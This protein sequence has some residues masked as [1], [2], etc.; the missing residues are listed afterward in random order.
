MASPSTID[1][2]KDAA[3]DELAT[4]TRVSVCS[5]EPANFAG[6]AAVSLATYALT[7]GTGGADW[8]IADGATDGRS[9]TMAA[10]TGNNGTATGVANFV[11]WDDGTTL[12][13]VRDGNG[14]TVNDGSAANI[15]ATVAWTVR[16]ETNV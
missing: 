10:Q 16:D 11:V 7:A 4:A 9:L 6:I 2:L 1:A 5:A 14:S 3:L 15:A 12:L 13:A 8:S